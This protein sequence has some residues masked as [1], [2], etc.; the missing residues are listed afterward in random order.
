MLDVRVL[1]SAFRAA[2]FALHPFAPK[3]SD[4]ALL[5]P[6]AISKISTSSVFPACT[7]SA[8]LVPLTIPSAD[9]SAAITNI[10]AGSVR[11]PGHGGDL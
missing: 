1:A 5:P 2:P 4:L 9:F 11:S 10:A 7:P 8:T 3:T 6:H